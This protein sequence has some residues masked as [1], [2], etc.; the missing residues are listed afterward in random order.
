M[1]QIRVEYEGDLHCRLEHGP[2]GAQIVTDA[3]ADNQGRGESFSP[4]DLLAASLG[5]CIMTVMGIYARRKE[6]DLR[7]SSVQ[8]TKE[9]VHDPLRR[10]GRL[11]V[12]VD[13]PGGIEAAQRQALENAAHTCPVERSLHPDIKVDL[14][15]RYRPA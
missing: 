8:V 13:L 12:V 10:V 15:F 5:S 9:M 4:S 11:T 7:G 6:I 2:S 1:S 3:P 14:Q